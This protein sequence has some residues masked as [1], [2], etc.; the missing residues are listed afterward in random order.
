VEPR[1][2]TALFANLVSQWRKSTRNAATT[3]SSTDG[4][5]AL[6]STSVTA[7]VAGS[8]AWLAAGT[9]PMDVGSRPSRPSLMPYEL[10][11]RLAKQTDGN[12]SYASFAPLGSSRQI[13][14]VHSDAASSLDYSLATER[15]GATEDSGIDTRTI[16]MGPGDTLVS[17]LTDAGVSDE[18]ASTAVVALAKVY[19][20]RSLRAG[21]SF[22]LTFQSPP[23]EPLIAPQ[24]H[25]HVAQITYT[26]PP[27]ADDSDD[28]FS[29]SDVVNVAAAPAGKLL[30]VAFSPSVEH[31]VT[32][33]RAADGT[34][35]AHDQVLDLTEKLHR[36]G[37]T[38]DS[39]LYLSAMQAGIPADV[40]VQMIK[41]FSYEVDFQRDLRPGNSFEVL[42]SY[43]YTPNGKPVKV[44]NIQYAAMKIGGR[45][46]ALYRFD[47]KGPDGPD[48]F[49]ADGQSARGMLMKTPV[50]GAR[51]SSGFGMRFHPILGYTRMHKGIDF[52]VPV[53]TPVMAAGSGVIKYEGT[54]RGYGNFLLIDHQDGYSTAYAHLSRFAPGTHVGSHVRQ[55]QVVAYSG[56]TGLTTGPHLHYEVRINGVQVNPA[57]VKVAK[58]IKLTGKELVAFKSERQHI[59]TEMASLPLERKI[60]ENASTDL[61]AAKD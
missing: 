32:I 40:V 21:Q 27:G 29:D 57:T 61:R 45:T 4:R 22:D 18:D 39:S 6:V 34:F 53:G 56:N 50:D 25:G 37:A 42:Y 5:W 2:A 46:I 15:S 17:A 11:L 7:I 13:S 24:T 38:I 51:I 28:D 31:E 58:G 3:L 49:D 35:A 41:M 9:A 19:D 60:A 47:P 14:P 16:T 26:P 12:A 20:V 1:H 33:A 59:Q 55:G 8:I 44:G 54:E 23:R 52:A 48:Y 36:A 10:F 30:S 43:Y